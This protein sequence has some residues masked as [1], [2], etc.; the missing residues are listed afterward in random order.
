MRRQEIC[1]NEFTEINSTCTNE[2]KHDTPQLAI[3]GDRV[4]G[5]RVVSSALYPQACLT[6]SAFA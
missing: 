5:P 6:V 2:H 1:E 3:C 4:L